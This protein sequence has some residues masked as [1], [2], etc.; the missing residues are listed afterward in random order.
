MV[1]KLPDTDF[2]ARREVLELDDFAIAPASEPEPTDLVTEETWKSIVRLP[3]DVAIYTS[4]HHGT[5]LT[6]ID[7]MCMDW[8]ETTIIRHQHINSPLHG[9]FLDVYDEF[10]GSLFNLT[11]GYYRQSTNCLRSAL[12]YITRGLCEEIETLNASGNKTSEEPS[13]NTLCER[14]SNYLPNIETQLTENGKDCLFGQKNHPPGFSGGWVRRH[15]SALS[16]FAHVRRNTSNADIWNSTGPVYSNSGF[17][18]CSSLIRE[19]NALCHLLPRLTGIKTE[20][21]I[22][23]LVLKSD[24]WF[25]ITNLIIRIT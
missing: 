6:Q 3:D 1:K 5:E 25:E 21:A 2:R 23:T 10:Q 19:T 24:S 9:A 17:R 16:K 18:T 8:V 12:E 4:N 13:F 20:A 7:K 11:H 22:N 14:L 15:Y